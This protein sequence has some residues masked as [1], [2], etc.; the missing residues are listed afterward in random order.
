MLELRLTMKRLGLD[1]VY[2]RL[3]ELCDERKVMLCLDESQRAKNPRSKIFHA[4]SAL[5]PSTRRRVLLSGTPTPKDISD[6]WAQIF[7]LDGGKRL[8]SNFYRW[9][10]Q[11]AELGNKW[12]EFAVKRYIPEAVEEVSLKMQEILLRRKKEDVVDLPEKLFSVRY[13]TLTGTQKKRYEEVCRELVIRISASSGKTYLRQIDSILEEFLRA[14]Q[15]ASNPRLVDETWKGEPVKFLELDEIVNEIVKEREQ[16]LVVWTNYRRNAAELCERYA[17]LGAAEFTGATPTDER[18]RIINCFQSATSKKINILIAIPAAGGVG[19]TLTA[20][21]TAVYL[22]KTWNAE[23]WLQ[24]IDR[25]HRI[26]QSGTVQI[27]SLHASPVDELI[28]RNLKKKQRS[29]AE[30]VGDLAERQ[31]ERIPKP[32]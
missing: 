21:Q 1:D 7:V 20:A 24:S 17:D 29:Q 22:D 3:R 11:V 12:S 16:K 26:G 19:I 2:P 4:L 14:V 25:V 18:Q 30:L 10:E 6:I 31:R 15:I 32:R 8:G 5:A 13:L 23:H 27:I 9:L 28:Y